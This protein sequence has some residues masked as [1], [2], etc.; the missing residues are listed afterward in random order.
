MPTTALSARAQHLVDALWREVARFGVVGLAAFVVDVGISNW[1]WGTASH[2]GPMH[3]SA[4]KAKCLSVAVATVV[5]YLGNR[6]WTYRHRQRPAVA[7]EFALFVLFNVVGMAIAAACLVV[8][9]YVLELR[10]ALARN[11]AGNGVGLVL[12]TAFRFWAY[13]TFVFT[14]DRGGD[15]ELAADLPQAQEPSRSH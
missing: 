10:N 5:A 6:C 7:H 9:D 13:R 15:P 12:G 11:I 2:P 4:T 1:L 3:D 8:N 14:H